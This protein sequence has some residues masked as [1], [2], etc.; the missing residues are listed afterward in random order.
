MLAHAPGKLCVRY[1]LEIFDIKPVAVSNKFV[2]DLFLVTILLQILLWQ[3]TSGKYN[4]SKYSTFNPNWY[5]LKQRH[6]VGRRDTN[7]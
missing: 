1:L 7:V 6:E 2:T 5:M 4:D 3:H